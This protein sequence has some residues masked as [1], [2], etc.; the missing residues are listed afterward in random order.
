MYFQK[1]A[2][3]IKD[4]KKY[5]DVF[6]WDEYYVYQAYRWAGH[7]SRMSVWAPRRLTHQTMRFRDY[8]YLTWLEA[9]FGDQCHGRRLHIWRWEHMLVKSF[10]RV[11]H[12]LRLKAEHWDD[13]SR[14]M[15]SSF[16]KLPNKRMRDL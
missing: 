13:A 5:L 8:K 7:V 10:G 14:R 3:K 2:D 12:D 4:W 6:N 1:L 9:E 11:W 15:S 16:C